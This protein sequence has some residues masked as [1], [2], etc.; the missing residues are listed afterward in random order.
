MT[1]TFITGATGYVGSYVAKELLQRTSCHLTLHVRARDATAGWERVWQAL[2][3]HM[4]FE[5]FVG[6]WPRLNI[7]LGDLGEPEL[8]L[9]QADRDM[10]IRST[11]SIIHIGAS[12]HRKSRR[13]TTRINMCGT[14]AL[15]KL[16]KA[17]HLHHGLRRFTNVSTTAVSGVCREQTIYE[18]IPLDWNQK[19]WDP[20]G[21][22]KKFSEHLVRE[23]LDDISQVHIRPT[24]VIG[25]TTT[26]VTT[27]FDMLKTLEILA[28]AVVIPLHPDA[29]IDIVPVDYTAN[30]IVHLHLKDQL[31]HDMYHVSAG[32][33]AVQYRD[34]MATFRREQI[35]RPYL[36]L[37]RSAPVAMR[38]SRA[39]MSTPRRWGISYM[40]SLAHVF[41]PILIYNLTFD[42][43][44][45]VEELGHAPM[46]FV[47]YGGKTL[48]YAIDHQFRYDYLSWPKGRSTPAR[49]TADHE[50]IAAQ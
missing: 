35:G 48:R 47:H 45:I 22:T 27:Q 23:L 31:K 11:E 46:S 49:A 39:L 19:D 26:P 38:L 33:Q 6:Y 20:Y 2:Q 50:L 12:L 9:T 34:L 43:R 10:L 32:S 28:N 42:N 36:F 1:T 18:D 14:L 7:V 37:P 13:Q 3:P 5:T 24:G 41:L 8:G 16:A 17:A 40:A 25:D 15:V 4:D 30:A 21:Q 29:R 44:R